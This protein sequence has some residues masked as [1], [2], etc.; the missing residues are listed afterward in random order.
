M[1][2]LRSEF[3][4]RFPKFNIATEAV[5]AKLQTAKSANSPG[6]FV[7][8]IRTGAIFPLAVSETPVPGLLARQA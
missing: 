5:F 2:I 1:G 3:P 8:N 6:E 7:A 4:S